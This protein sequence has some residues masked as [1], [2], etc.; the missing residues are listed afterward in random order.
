M[1]IMDSANG[2]AAPSP[3]APVAAPDWV[4]DFYAAVD[5]GDGPGALAQMAPDVAVQVAARP[6]ARGRE[7]AGA[8]LAAFHRSFDTVSHEIR[9][10]WA[11]DDT[12]ICEFVATYRLH[13]GRRLALPT[14][15]VLRR[16]GGLI[17]EM[18]VYV[19]EGALREGWVPAPVRSAPSA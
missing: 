11:A 17:A 2:P 16:A 6:V 18:R 7:A 12:V 19:D 1:N 14:L 5:G 13:D 15:T 9:N 8:T 3:A 4:S 10:V